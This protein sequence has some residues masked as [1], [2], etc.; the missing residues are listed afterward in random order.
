MAQTTVVIRWRPSSGG[1]AEL[2]YPALWQSSTAYRTL[3]S[4][5]S[6]GER[7]PAD[8]PLTSLDSPEART[9]T[10]WNPVP[11]QVG[12]EGRSTNS[13]SGREEASSLSG[14]PVAGELRVD[15]GSQSPPNSSSVGEWQSDE[16]QSQVV[17][18]M[19]GA[20][21]VERQPGWGDWMDMDWQD[22]PEPLPP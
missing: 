21:N 2:P 7:G 8:R 10:T 5:G 18:T 9:V 4:P 13:D 1:V 12:E 11:L 14:S 20:E 15:P 16:D 3:A 6:P 17:A 22:V 19:D